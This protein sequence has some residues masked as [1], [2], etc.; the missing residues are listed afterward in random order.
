MPQ[1]YFLAIAGNIGVGKT[2]LTDRLAAELGWKVYYE[3]VIENPYLDP[4]Y[5]DMQRWSFHLQIYFLAERFKAQV[6]IGQSG[7]AFIQDRTIYEDAEIFAKTLHEQGSMT[8]TDYENYI[9]LF[10]C[11]TGFLRPPDLIIYLHASP[12]TLLERIAKR[13]RESEKAIS[14]DYLARLGNAYDDWIARVSKV[15]E[16]KVIDTDSIPIKGP[17]PAFNE[18]VNELKRRYPPQVPLHLPRG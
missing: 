1:G 13:G 18:L 15:R 2:D 7:E 5:Q 3:P 14:R 10:H 9:E 11:M 16:V 8:K 12:D 4:F 17:T 6:R